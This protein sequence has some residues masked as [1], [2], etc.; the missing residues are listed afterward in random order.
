MASKKVLTGAALSLLLVVAIGGCAVEGQGTPGS[1]EQTSPVPSET[2]ATDPVTD[3][4]PVDLSTPEPSATP[5]LLKP[6]VGDVGV[7]ISNAGW[8]AT[9]G[10]TVR[11][12]ADTVDATATCTLELSIAGTTRTV[13]SEALESP[14]TMSCGELVVGPADLSP[15][16]WTA[17]LSYESAT[18]WG[19]SDPVVVIVP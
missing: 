17:V 6:V 16:T 9:T 18:A 15:G 2:T 1:E 3:P 8:D 10:V 5:E 4:P 12:Y 14:S 13:T 7:L 11:G 19:T